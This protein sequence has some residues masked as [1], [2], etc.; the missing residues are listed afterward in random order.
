MLDYESIIIRFPL[1]FELAGGGF[2][3]TDIDSTFWIWGFLQ[4]LRWFLN[5]EQ[6]TYPA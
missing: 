4:F 2:P 6:S 5:L 3:G 1:S